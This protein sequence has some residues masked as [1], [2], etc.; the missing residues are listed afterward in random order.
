MLRSPQAPGKASRES[1]SRLGNSEKVGLRDSFRVVFRFGAHPSVTAIAFAADT[2]H[3]ID[4]KY[5]ATAQWIFIYLKTLPF[6]SANAFD[7]VRE[8]APKPNKKIKAIALQESGCVL[9]RRNMIVRNHRYL[10]NTLDIDYRQ[11]L[12]QGMNS[13]FF[14]SPN[15][16]TEKVQ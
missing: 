11:P 1:K 9:R 13:T 15:R 5:G 14:D 3:P 8:L 10:V 6:A 4:D 2:A 16:D 12:R 7:M